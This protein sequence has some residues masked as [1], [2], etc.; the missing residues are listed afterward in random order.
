MTLTTSDE[1][2]LAG[3]TNSTAFNITVLPEVG[4]TGGLNYSGFQFTVTKGTNQFSIKNESGFDNAYNYVVLK[5][6][7]T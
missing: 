2:G 1:A 7:G 3:L 6:G 5:T 4:G